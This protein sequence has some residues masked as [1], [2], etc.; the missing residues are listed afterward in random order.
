MLIFDLNTIGNNL[1]K[2]RK[3]KSLTQ[4]EVAEKAVSK[5]LFFDCLTVSKMARD[6]FD[7]FLQ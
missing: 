2:I 4:A 3:S 6:F 5:R 7:T 1:Y